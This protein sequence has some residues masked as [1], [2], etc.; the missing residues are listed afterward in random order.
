MHIGLILAKAPGYSETFFRSMVIGLEQQGMRV[1]LFVQ[2][3]DSEFGLCEAREAPKAYRSGIALGFSIIGQIMYL[4][5]HIKAVG[6]FWKLERKQG[7]KVVQVFKSIYLNAH[8]LA[9]RV[10]WLHFGF[11][12]IALERENLARAI[13]AKMAVSLRGYDINVYPLKDLGCYK[14]LWERVDKVHSISAYLLKRAIALGLKEE[15]ASAVIPP[16]VDITNLPARKGRGQVDLPVDLVTAARLHW[17]KGLDIA[18]QAVKLLNDKGI[19][20][21]YTII[22]DGPKKDYERYAYLALSLGIRDRVHFAGKLTHKEAL[23]RVAACDIYLQPS[24]N[25]GFCNAVLEAQALGVPV[26]ASRVGGLPENI[27]DGVTGFLFKPGS[28]QELAKAIENIQQLSKAKKYEAGK[29]AKDRVIREFNL[30]Q[31]RAQFYR[32]YSS[33]S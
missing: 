16:A 20:A 14:L 5:P 11:A 32:F 30:E 7:K 17:I 25:E 1:V 26:A 24:L 12:T 29:Q 3:T 31:Q 19:D 18:I 23:G 28:P 6:R 10:D 21:H 8:I 15:T 22:G 9:S 33:G 27:V 13:G 2:K 4:L